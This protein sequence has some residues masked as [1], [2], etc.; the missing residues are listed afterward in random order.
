MSRYVKQISERYSVAYGFDHYTGYFFQMFDE[1]TE[2]GEEHLLI[3]ECSRFS[4]LS[5]GKMVEYMKHYEVNPD[6]IH[7]VMMDLPF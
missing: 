6:H 3:D 7:K 5:N 1:K 2:D 4:G